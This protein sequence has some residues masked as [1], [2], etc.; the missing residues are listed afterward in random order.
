MKKKIKS[1]ILVY[2]IS[3]IILA[4]ALVTFTGV[5]F[6]REA[7][8][9]T[10]FESTQILAK[11]I[12]HNVNEV[13]KNAAQ[14]VSVIAENNNIKQSFESPEKLKLELIKLKRILG[15]YDDITILNPSGE[16]LTSTDYNYPASWTHHKFFAATVELKAPQVS[17]AYYLPE[18]LRFIT[19][20]TAPVFDEKGKLKAVVSA[21]LNMKQIQSIVQH[22]TL[23]QTGHA[24]LIDEN[25]RY[26]SHYNEEKLLTNVDLGLLQKIEQQDSHL[27]LTFD[28]Q[29]HIGNYVTENERT[30][31]VLQ[32][33]DEVLSFFNDIFWNILIVSLVIAV[34][35]LLIG[36][37][38]SQS[39]TKPIED[40]NDT[41]HKFKQ[42]DSSAR[43]A[44][45]SQDE[46][47]E[48][49][50]DFN[51]MIKEVIEFREQLEELVKTRT[52]ELEKAKDEAETANRAKSAF[53]ANMSHEIRTPMNAILGFSQI[54][55]KTET[56]DEKKM[57]LNSITTGGKTLLS[58]IN[59][60]LDLSKIEAGKF[61]LMLNQSSLRSI[62]TETCTILSNEA[63]KKKLDLSF[64]IDEG[65]PQMVIIDELR[66]RQILIN[67]VGNAIKFTDS[68]F[69][70][71]KASHSYCDELNKFTSITIEVEDS[72][73]GISEDEQESIFNDFI[74]S[75]KQGDKLYQ[76][77]GL[78]LAICRKLIKL[79]KGKLSVES[80]LN[81][82]ATFKIELPRIEVSEIIIDDDNYVNSVA[83]SYLDFNNS[84]VLIVDDNED[85][86][87]FLV[88]LLEGH[89]IKTQT[90]SNC[91]KAIKLTLESQPDLILMDL[92]MPKLSGYQAAETIKANASTKDIPI[93][94]V[95]A[96]I[97]DENTESFKKL[98]ESFI[99]KPVN[100]ELLFNS[101]MNHLPYSYSNSDTKN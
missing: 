18:P 1:R 51:L 44:I 13:Y 14:N 52:D 38:L 76:G 11:E 55:Q 34:L 16:V 54:L 58:I 79:M 9:Q 39:L 87:N 21:Q 67:L 78:G 28:Q 72:G 77:T 83:N 99:P 89:N 90:A 41:I 57:F 31:I 45:S 69:V 6:A 93:L 17:V 33:R 30:L 32:E 24:Y 36:L 73:I 97:V 5:F 74:Q 60:I 25:K 101:L 10:H 75:E 68:G 49:A 37:K 29:I 26:I 81:K 82:G 98:F 19:S 23:D 7:S 84:T 50:N 47:G 94:A 4:I 56:D 100:S 42:G 46:I 20:F 27:E 91:E 80:Q 85:N 65:F 88:K 12:L 70:K 40:L 95:S 2:L 66:L 62:V 61:T 92:K 35:A 96:S 53:L 15:T 22:L 59:D 63:K 43:A 3:L 48:L 86:L 8:L 64:E 71:I